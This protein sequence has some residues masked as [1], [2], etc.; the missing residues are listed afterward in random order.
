MSKIIISPADQMKYDKRKSEWGES[1]P[2]HNINYVVH[3][4]DRTNI[5]L[6]HTGYVPVNSMEQQ[7]KRTFT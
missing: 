6:N 5:V 3:T 7:K 1:G 4:T 2:A